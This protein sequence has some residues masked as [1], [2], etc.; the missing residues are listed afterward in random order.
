MPQKF[1]AMLDRRQMAGPL[2][3]DE[4][5]QAVENGPRIT[6]IAND[7]ATLRRVTRR[8]IQENVGVAGAN[9]NTQASTSVNPL[10]QQPL[11]RLQRQYQH[12]DGKVRRVPPSWEFPKIS[13]LAM[14]QYWH[15][16]DATKKIP[17]MKYLH[18]SDVDYLGKGSRVRLAEVRKIMTA[19]DGE[20]TAKG[21][22]PQEH[23]D[24][25]QAATCY[26]HGESII[27]ATIPNKTAK[28]RIRKVEDMRW[29]TV[30]K[31]MHKKRNTSQ[32]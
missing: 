13:L 19:I 8:V 30:V 20:A 7:I 29:G 22:P 2:S 6:A 21:Y 14:Y 10:T 15:Y 32:Q 9:N 28:G 25:Q 16:G 31:Y 12:P 23:M 4:I 26:Y 27:L 11:A 24:H 1:E 5:A 18:A 3:L 17:P